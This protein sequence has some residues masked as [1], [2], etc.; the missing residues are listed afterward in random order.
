M[1]GRM[2]LVGI[3]PY[4]TLRRRKCNEEALWSYCTCRT[5][6]HPRRALSLRRPEVLRPDLR[7]DQ[8]AGGVLAC[9]PVRS[10][11]LGLQL[12]RTNAVEYAAAG[13]DLPGRRH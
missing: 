7:N 4:P 12:A 5:G 6:R 8:C 1:F 9:L 2:A 3:H 10:D 11:G 13:L